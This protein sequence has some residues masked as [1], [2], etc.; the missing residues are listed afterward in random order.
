MLS[1]TQSMVPNISVGFF[2]YFYGFS[3]NLPSMYFN[4]PCFNFS[5][6]PVKLG[7]GEYC[8]KKNENWHKHSFFGVQF[9]TNRKIEI[10]I[11]VVDCCWVSIYSSLFAPF[12]LHWLHRLLRW[13]SMINSAILREEIN[14]ENRKWLE[15]PQEYRQYNFHFYLKTSRTFRRLKQI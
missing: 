1:H 13:L 6:S 4:R 14:C 9:T 5:Y 7:N 15:W 12:Q 3:C 2:L 8:L 11:V 10:K